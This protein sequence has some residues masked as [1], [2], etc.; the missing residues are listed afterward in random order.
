[1]KYIKKNKMIP[2]SI[3]EKAKERQQK[4]HSKRKMPRALISKGESKI[5]IYLISVRK[6]KSNSEKRKSD[7]KKL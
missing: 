3:L 6:I 4:N 5:I 1:M 7:I 2:A